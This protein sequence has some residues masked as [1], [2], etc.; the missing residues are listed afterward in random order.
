MK[1]S[2]LMFALGLWLVS[3][4]KE[5]G[6]SAGDLLRGSFSGYFHR[7]GMDTV[8]VY[9]DFSETTFTGYSSRPKYPAICRGAWQNNGS[10][11]NFTDSCTWTADFDWT[12]ILN[13]NYNIS[14]ENDNRIRIR[15]MTGAVKDEYLLWHPVR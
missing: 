1:M 15:R 7:T 12:L 14:I 9:L 3:C 11:I 10:T 8:P 6:D 4:D 2:L 13:G 5:T